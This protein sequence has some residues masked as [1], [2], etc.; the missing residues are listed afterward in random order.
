MELFHASNFQDRS[1]EEIEK[2]QRRARA[3]LDL[4]K[5]VCK[6]RGNLDENRATFFSPSEDWCLPASST[7]KPEEREFVVD[8]GALSK[9][10]LNVAEMDIVQV[11]RR[12]TTV[13]TANG[14]IET[15][16]EATVDVKGLH[17]FVTVQLLDD[18]PPVVSLGQLCED[19]GYSYEWIEGIW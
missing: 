11:S 19:H 7:F 2:E 18:T 8:S 3:A 10:D 17:L 12:T 4:A 14:S 15:N 9:R 1:Q 13:I 6:N 16:E 5:Q